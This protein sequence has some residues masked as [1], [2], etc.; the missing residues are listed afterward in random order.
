MTATEAQV[1]AAM[2]ALEAHFM[3]RIGKQSI[4]C[5]CGI[6][7]PHGAFVV[8]V[9]SISADAVVAAG[10]DP[11]KVA[12]DALVWRDRGQIIHDQQTRIAQ[13]ERECLDREATETDARSQ[14]AMAEGQVAELRNLD[15]EI[16]G[17]AMKHRED[18][19]RGG[20]TCGFCAWSPEHVAI[21]AYRE[22][23]G[24]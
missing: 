4:E 16:I 3:R 23:V 8:H 15:G 12:A 5:S 6:D 9:G 13:L 21:M 20:C 18:T 14:L 24:R 10:P 2:E 19:D 1:A 11:A 17:E 7:I 22:A